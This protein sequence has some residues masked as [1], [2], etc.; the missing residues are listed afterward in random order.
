[1]PHC[2]AKKLFS[3]I[4]LAMAAMTSWGNSPKLNSITPAGGQRGS[5]VEINLNGSRLEGAKELMFYS[6]GFEVVK[7]DTSKTNAVKAR[8]RISADCELGE[9][10]LRVRTASGL[11]EV[12][13][14]FIS[15]F[16][17]IQESEPNND[18]AKPQKIAMN[19]T[20]NGSAGQDDI[21]YFQVDARQGGRIAVEVEGMRLGRSVF[22]PFIAILDTKGKTLA[23]S[24]DTSL[25]MQDGAISVRAPE[26]GTYL[27]LIRETSYAGTPNTL[28]RLH[29]GSYPRP[30]IVYP[31]G[32]QTGEKL[33]VAFVGDAS[34]DIAQ[35]L[36]LPTAPADRFAVFARQGE[37]S[38]P[39]PNW[40]RVSPF[41]NVLES[42]A[43]Q[44]REQATAAPGEPPF[45]LNGI[46]SKDGEADWFRF[47]ARKGTALDVVV[48]ARRLRSP[49]DS[50]IEILDAKGKSLAQNDDAASA[51]SSVKFTPAED[52]DY[53]LKI[54]DQLMKGAADYVYRIEVTAV[55]QALSLGI[56]QAARN[57]SQTRQFIAVASGNRMATLITARRANFTGPV[58]VSVPGL[59]RG[60]TLQTE[61]MLGKQNEMPI[62]FEA[63]GDA[64]LEGRLLD[65]VGTTTNGLRGTYAHNVE[66]I[67][68]PNNSVYYG[69][70]LDKL[71]VAVTEPAP[72]K[73]RV[74]EPKVPLVQGGSMD[75][76]IIADRQPGF[77]DAITLKM[78]WNP[79]GVSSQPEIVLP[80]GQSSISYPLNANSGADAQKWKIAVLGSTT[81][82]GGTIW[83]STQLAG[84]EVAAPF[85]T[86][87]IETLAIEPG[88]KGKLICKL[89]QQVPFEGKAKVRLMGLPDKVTAKE[90]EVTSADKEVTFEVTVAADCP[91]RSTRVLFCSVMVQKDGEPVPHGIASGGVIRI[92]PP[93]KS[94]PAADTKVASGK[95]KP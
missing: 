2:S 26:D 93:K 38:A 4:F 63:A 15:A 58:E 47:K 7:L 51:D 42:S 95:P 48:Y 52:G 37:M 45:A 9:H 65:L 23:S 25:L 59:P 32:G 1:M 44:T 30:M 74:V 67:Y 11:S 92:T 77:E 61:T 49:L 88:Q 10:F 17:N 73:I 3:A 69:Q 91:T 5:E 66:F 53:F 24:D 14:F 72:F 84:I 20:V 46:V 6:P 28:Y 35:T 18:P 75:L 64:Q 57:D 76:K 33:L 68:G 19:S 86:G 71:A 31:A 12:R 89:D 55:S 62:V 36:S 27:V 8:L 34:G 40:V 41:A 94:G 50:V 79:P 60:I 56:P 87:K 16:P 78:L 81:V 39:S 90:T 29:I 70:K 83:A 13:N 22:D 54:N 85:L 21:D 43:N 80:K 82:N